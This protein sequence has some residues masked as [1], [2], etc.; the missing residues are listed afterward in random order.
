VPI[1]RRER[2]SARGSRFAFIQMS[3]TSGVFEVMAFAEVLAASRQLLDTG[4]PLLVTV[5]VRTDDE[6]M[7]LS[8]QRFEP[9]DKIVADAAAG[10]KVFLGEPD[11][12]MPLKNLMAREGRGRGRV[13]VIVPV[14]PT[15]EVEIALPGGFRIGPDIR[16]MVRALP[17][18]LEVQDI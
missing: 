15:R 12:L 10:L 3:D 13:S 5:D 16:R 1:A 9:L 7:R 6:S 8:A 11:A 14:A 4:G 17:G 18:V 2:N